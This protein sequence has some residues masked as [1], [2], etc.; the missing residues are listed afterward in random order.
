MRNEFTAIIEKDEDWY[1]AYCPEIPGANG[2][3]KTKEEC[4]KSLSEAIRLILEDR[5]R[6]AMRGIPQDAVSD[7]V[8]VE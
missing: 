8:A 4:L 5:R 1:I 6:D 7:V 2:Q 3:G